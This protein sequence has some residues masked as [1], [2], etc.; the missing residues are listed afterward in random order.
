MYREKMMNLS[1]KKKITKKQNPCNFIATTKKW[2]IIPS[3]QV[4]NKY[5]NL[6]S[7]LFSYHTAFCLNQ[8]LLQSVITPAT[9]LKPHMMLI[10]LIGRHHGRSALTISIWILCVPASSPCFLLPVFF[11]QTGIISV[12]RSLSA[13]AEGLLQERFLLLGTCTSCHAFLTVGSRAVTHTKAHCPDT[14]DRSRSLHSHVTSYSY[15]ASLTRSYANNCA[16]ICLFIC[17]LS[18]PWF[19]HFQIVWQF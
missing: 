4:F 2:T 14:S 7:C 19:F 6:P 13:S 8:D 16:P 1:K 3:C 11:K 9:W 10:D 15:F 5:L 18:L 17:C 12:Y